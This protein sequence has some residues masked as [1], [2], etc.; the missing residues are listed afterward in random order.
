[1]LAFRCALMLMV[2]LIGGALSATAAAAQIYV[3]ESTV[4]AI[5]VGSALDLR[6]AISIP[7]GGHIRAVLPSGKTQTIKGPYEGTVA[8]L[9]KGQP[10]NE[11]VLAWIK[12]LVRTGGATQTTPGATRSIGRPADKPRAAFSWSAIPVANGT[13]C[14][15]KGASLTLIR[16][17]SPNAERATMIDAANGKQAELQWEQG[18]DTAAWPASLIPRNEGT[19]EVL[20]AGRPRRQI[21]VRVLDQLPPE[22]NLLIELNR[23]GCSS[24]FEAWVRGKLAAGN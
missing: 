17:A 12:D 11:G 3:M 13:V 4:A 9:A 14:V 19:Y 10:I 22:D 18:S 15:E 7:A 16:V 8:D 5:R 2:G 1:M 6:A 23:L 20:A 24:Q 21:T